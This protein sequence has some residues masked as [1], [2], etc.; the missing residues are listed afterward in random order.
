MTTAAGPLTLLTFAADGRKYGIDVAEVVAVL[1]A[2]GVRPVD[3]APEWLRG[4]L[5]F[6][7]RL[8]PVVDVTAMLRGRASKR[9]FGTRIV[10]VRGSSGGDGTGPAALMAE[11]VLDIVSID[12]D[13]VQPSGVRLP[14]APWLGPIGTD[15]EGALLQVIHPHAL[16]PAAVRD[17]LDL[18]GG[19]S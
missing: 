5:T 14:D 16:L 6:R 1:P 13:R 12:A 8:L 4:V 19:T 17:A 3:R 11:N 10:I 7:G 9:A 2:A 18:E 15:A